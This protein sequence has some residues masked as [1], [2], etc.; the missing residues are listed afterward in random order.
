MSQCPNCGASVAEMTEAVTGT[1]YRVFTHTSEDCIKNLKNQLA[2]YI[3]RCTAAEKMRDA[4][5]SDNRVF[6]KRVDEAQAELSSFRKVFSVNQRSLNELTTKHEQLTCEYNA[7]S[8]TL[9]TLRA[10]HIAEHGQV[11]ALKRELARLTASYE[12]ANKR[13]DSWCLEAR[14]L[15]QLLNEARN[16]KDSSKLWKQLETQAHVM[17]QC[18]ANQ[19]QKEEPGVLDSLITTAGELVETLKQLKE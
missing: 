7:I 5:K 4:L 11:D 13:G 3:E 16:G 17:A 2:C 9:E 10:H 19:Q 14:R 18:A 1:S 15:E 8:S 6:L 12:A